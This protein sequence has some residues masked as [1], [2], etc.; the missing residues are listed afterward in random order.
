MLF[1]ESYKIVNFN[2]F[3]HHSL[4]CLEKT[5]FYFLP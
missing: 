1:F 3:G 5:L 4:F 2:F